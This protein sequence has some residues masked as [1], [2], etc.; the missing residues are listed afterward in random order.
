MRNTEPET[1]RSK[2]ETE[3][4]KMTYD[5]LE[6]ALVALSIR[7]EELREARSMENNRE[8]EILWT[9]CDKMDEAQR[10]L[11]SRMSTEAEQWL[12]E[13]TEKFPPKGT[14]AKST[15]RAA[16]GKS[17]VKRQGLLWRL[18]QITRL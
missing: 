8:L 7:Q 15:R 5:Q 1:R 4:V 14:K 6:M 9:V 10:R 12:T 13:I 17:P 11:E 3:L 2:P 16:P 18:S